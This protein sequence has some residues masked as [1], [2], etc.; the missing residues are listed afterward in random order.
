VSVVS[1]LGVYARVFRRGSRNGTDLVRHLIRR[2][3]I[4]AAV[5]AYETALFVSGRASDRLKVLAQVK[6]SSMI[7][8][9]F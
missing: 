3:A 7:G 5:G 9:P 8:C 2:P 6:T 4:L 1:K